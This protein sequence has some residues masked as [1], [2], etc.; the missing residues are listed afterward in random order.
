[1]EKALI[2]SVCYDIFSRYECNLVREK[3]DFVERCEILVGYRSEE[4]I[5]LIQIIMYF[6]VYQNNYV[7]RSN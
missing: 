6:D 5:L 1:M 4:L 3:N 2:V 7:Q